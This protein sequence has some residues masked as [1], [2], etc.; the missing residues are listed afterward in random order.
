M[1]PTSEAPSPLLPLGAQ[2]T[3][4]QPPPITG[5]RSSSRAPSPPTE[6]PHPPASGFPASLSSLRLVEKAGFRREDLGGDT[7]PSL[8]HSPHHHHVRGPPSLL[9]TTVGRSAGRLWGRKKGTEEAKV[10]IECPAIR[11]ES[12]LQAQESARPPLRPQFC[13]SCLG[14]QQSGPSGKIGPLGDLGIPSSLPTVGGRGS[15]GLSLS[16]ILSGEFRHPGPSPLLSLV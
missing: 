13:R 4:P 8:L 2:K 10:R 3:G 6:F 14:S 7:E 5:P 15:R 9:A 16:L 1:N 12:R 11:T